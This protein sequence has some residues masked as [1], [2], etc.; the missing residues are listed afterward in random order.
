MNSD[1]LIFHGIHL[2]MDYINNLLQCHFYRF[3]KQTNI[4][5]CLCY[6]L[7]W[8]CYA[9]ICLSVNSLHV[10]RSKNSLSIIL[11]WTFLS[12]CKSLCSLYNNIQSNAIFWFFSKVR[13]NHGLSVVS[14]FPIRYTKIPVVCCVHLY[15]S[16]LLFSIFH[17]K[18]ALKFSEHAPCQHTIKE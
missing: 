7:R 6:W 11:F 12:T 4:L 3:D 17:I 16:H 5:N 8:A 18:F 10:L 14:K 15:S 9:I 13:A 2:L 1:A